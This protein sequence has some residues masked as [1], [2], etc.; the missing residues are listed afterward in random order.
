[1]DYDDLFV[2][3]IGTASPDPSVTK[4][5]RLTRGAG[6]WLLSLDRSLVLMTLNAQE[7]LS[8]RI[9]ESLM[10]NHY[11][12][13]DATPSADEARY[14]KLDLANAR[15]T[16]VLKKLAQQAASVALRRP[17]IRAFLD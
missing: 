8:Q 10:A 9:V 11:M 14:L 6:G 5:G 3:G 1:V 2:L 12:R 4:E 17:A 15:S 16:Q 7:E 13:I